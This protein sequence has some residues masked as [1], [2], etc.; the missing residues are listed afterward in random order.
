MSRTRWVVL[1]VAVGVSAA[2]VLHT[3]L[4]S[5]G[6]GRRE[7]VRADLEALRG[8]NRELEARG[9]HLRAQVKALRERPE[10]QERV[11]RDELGYVKPGEIVLEIRDAPVD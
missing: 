3:L 9:T 4:D 2:V 6:F 8:A 10:V 11:L 7:Q 1:L 5:D